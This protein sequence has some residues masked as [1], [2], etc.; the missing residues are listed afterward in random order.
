MTKTTE[1]KFGT[2]GWRAKIADDYTFDNVR[3]VTEAIAEYFKN[4][5]TADKGIAIGYDN[6]FQSEDFA[7]TAAEVCA[8]SGIKTS[9]TKTSVASPVLSYAVNKYGHCCGIMITAS[10]NPPE[11][12]GVKIKESFGGSAR[13]E[14][15][16]QVE[17]LVKLAPLTPTDDSKYEMID[18]REDYLDHIA[19]FVDCKGIAERNLEVVVDPMHGSG[20]G[21][22]KEIMAKYGMAITEIEEKR[23][24][25][26]GGF[27]PEPLPVNLVELTSYMKEVGLKS[28]K[29]A[30]GI[31]LDGD[32]DRISAVDPSGTFINT[33]N[34]FCL[35]LKH[36]AVNRKMKGSVVKT[37]NI[38]RI[39]QKQA[40]KYGLKLHE[41]PIGFKHVVDIMMKEDVLLG[42]EES[43]GYGIYGNIPERDGSLCGLLLMELMAYEQK[44]LK[45]ILD[46]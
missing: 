45:Q 44:T 33:Q 38:T 19:H 31:A 16:K 18:P 3:R 22:I 15:T 8:N 4:S 11:W 36:L 26:F 13:P 39:A 5:G 29:I 40:K 6:R 21:Y 30:C 24:P 9:L 32:G 25:T 1:I 23:D 2:D 20:S 42:G 7:R 14:V 28:K 10:H 17:Q 46:E 12:N 35:L 27:N 43:G 41:V 34:V 37:F